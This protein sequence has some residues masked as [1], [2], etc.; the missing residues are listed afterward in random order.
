MISGYDSNNKGNIII[1]ELKQWSGNVTSRVE[2]KDGL[3]E[4]FLAGCIRETTHPSYQAWSYFS[5]IRDFNE[6]VQ[7]NLINLYPCAYLHNYDPKY[8]AEI[9]NEIYSYYVDIAPLYLKGDALKL[10]EFIAKHI[11]IGD[12]KQNLYEINSGKIKPSK[13]LQDSVCKMLKGNDEF[14]MIDSQ[15]IIFE[16]AL[17]FGLKSHK[18]N[19]K[20]VLIVEGGPGTGK[21][22]L[23]INLLVKFIDDDLVTQYVSK[24]SAPRNVYSCKLK[25]KYRTRQ[26]NHLFRGSGSYH[27][28]KSNVFSALLVD[29]AHRLN[30]KSGLFKNFGE[31]QIKEIINASK[32]SLF[33]IDENQK[34]DIFDIGSKEEIEKYAKKLG[35]EVYIYKLD[36]QFRCNGSN[37]YLAWLDD[38]LQIH[39]TANFDS[40]EMNYDFKIFDDPN[41]MMK[42]IK[43]LNQ[44]NNKSRMVAGY[45][46]DW[47]SEGKNNSLIHDITIGDNF[48]MSW[49]LRSSSTWAIDSESIEEIGCIHTCQGLEFDY[50]GVIIGNDLRYEDGKIITDFT[51][52]AKT[53]QSLKGIKT[54]AKKNLSK[55]EE[56]AENIIKNTYRTLMTRGQKGCYIYCCDKNLEQYLKQ[57]LNIFSKNI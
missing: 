9:D 5:F 28:C 14:I 30:E 29:E 31:N 35:A 33:F 51:E 16:N 54:M 40:F 27:N 19:K 17:Q 48:K 42:A 44:I 22:V 11:K 46:W 3:V 32:F 45:C 41:K 15:K 21:S 4:T 56:I 1:I 20:R 53:D 47:L 39:E 24:N 23:A 34:V 7:E 38:V 13:S 12:N 36:S 2:G 55:A 26:I 25:G 6:N 43:K 50:V 57:R 8:K 10:R 18:D 37:G 52:R 49:N